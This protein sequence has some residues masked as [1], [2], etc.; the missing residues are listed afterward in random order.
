MIHAGGTGTT[1]AE[2]SGGSKAELICCPSA[3]P[4][5][6]SATRVGVKL[7]IQR[8]SGTDRCPADERWGDALA[9]QLGYAPS[10]AEPSNHAV[11]TLSA[12]GAGVAVDLVVERAG[13]APWHER[14][15]SSDCACLMSASAIAL[16]QTLVPPRA[17]R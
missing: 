7:D 14:F 13:A 15:A 3:K 5:E 2:E 4:D 10:T 1:H 16:A 8:G 11:V 12:D 6:S 9:Q 17:S